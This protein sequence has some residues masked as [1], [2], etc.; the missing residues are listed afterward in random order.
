MYMNKTYKLHNSFSALL[1]HMV[2]KNLANN[3]PGNVLLPDGTK[4]L[5]EPVSIN[6]SS[7]RS[8]AIPMIAISQGNDLN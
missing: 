8:W 2:P 4:P 7:V 3:D 1:S 6:Q 5:P